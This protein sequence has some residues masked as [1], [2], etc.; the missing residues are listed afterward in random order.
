MLIAYSN[1]LF[2]HNHGCA[3]AVGVRWGEGSARVW[4]Y[5]ALGGCSP[6]QRTHLVAGPAHNAR[7][8]GNRSCGYALL[9]GRESASVEW[10]VIEN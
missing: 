8:L 5:G 1:L 10:F 3:A 2:S 4:C 7:G 6:R 9:N